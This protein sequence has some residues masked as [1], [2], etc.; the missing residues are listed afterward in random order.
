MSKPAAKV[1]CAAIVIAGLATVGLTGGRADSLDGTPSESFLI[2]TPAIRYSLEKLN[3]LGSVL[4]IGAH[5]DDEN[6]AV[7]AWTSRGLKA[8]TGYLSL[9]RGEGGQNLLGDEQGPLL[10]VVRTQELLAARRDDGGSQYFTRAID[11]GFTTSLDETL[12]DWGR[13]KILADVVW[14][15]RQQQ[16]D[17]IIDV[18]SGTPADG[19]G[20]HQAA[21]VLGKEA[22][23]AAGDPNRFPEQLKWVKPWK[24]HRLMRSRFTPPPGAAAP[25]RGGRGGRG[26]AQ[27]AGG[28]GPGRVD[29]YPDQ[30]TL[31]IDTGEFDPVI[32]RSYRE[33]SIVSR[34]EHRSQGQGSQLAY[35]SAEG[36]LATV[37]GDVPKKS[38]FE[39]IDVSWNRLPGGA[40]IGAILAK[41]Q[42]DID[43]LHP[44]KTVPA[45]LEARSLIAGLAHDEGQGWAQWKLDDIDE[46]I[47]LC[48]GLHTEVEAD[49]PTYVPGSTAKLQLTALNRSSLPLMLKGIHLSGWGDVDAPVKDVALADNKPEV[50]TVSVPI[51]SRQPWSQPF[52]LREPHDPYTYTISD[53][54]LIGRADTIPEVLARFDFALGSSAFSVTT[55]IHYRYGDPAR[56]QII[57]PVVVEPPVAIDLPA[58]NVVYPLGS[59]RDFSV[60]IRAL[61]ANQSGDVRLETPAGWKVQP[62]TAPFSLKESGSSQE[63]RFRLTPPANT[64]NGTFK[65]V[66]KV[67]GVEVS[68]GLDVIAYSHIPAQTVLLPAGGKLA[69]VPLKVLA[70]RVGYIMG[71]SDKEPEALRQ[72][73]CQV[74][75]LTEKDLSSGNLA[76]YDAVVAGIRAYA[77]RPD[78]RANQ[79]RLLDYV[80]N[81]GTLVVQYNNNADRRISPS[82]AE[83]FDHMGPYSFQIA[84]ND[85]RVTD[86][87]AP[88]KVLQPDSPLLNVPNK[89]TQADF[90]GWIQERG[91]YFA[92]KWDEHYQTPLETHDPGD[93]DQSGALLYTRYGKGA[94]IFT[95]FSWFRELPAGVPGAYRIFANLISAGKAGAG[96]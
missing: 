54:T 93:K 28:R 55:P 25:G 13:E 84:G 6:N 33:I 53:Q 89:I 62:A 38:L 81:G 7:L 60:Q 41:A 27:A 64:L 74:D 90:E 30:P 2:G 75:L 87:N 70:R 65:V 72:M 11:F 52:W 45:L 49:A 47:A 59:P 20:N 95:A 35:G 63:V 36:L 42:S 17:V 82:V 24:A 56:G 16:P 19:H 66:A 94:Y 4:M 67:S 88:V 3:V 86:E 31:P 78:L 79:Q 58:A 9:N 37:E 10:G 12:K 71:S 32:G 76:A 68:N 85:A 1:L 57:R 61:T 77:L 21:G 96:K 50:A 15:I 92:S 80:K 18:F 44:E 8:R 91:L 43:D 69:A 29:A 40:R 48:A 73:G 5:P 34:S 83:A 23:E 46:A 26:G 22:Y 39:G 51:S 14:V